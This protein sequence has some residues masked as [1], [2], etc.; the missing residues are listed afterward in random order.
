MPQSVDSY[1]VGV[2]FKNLLFSG[3]AYAITEE[4]SNK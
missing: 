4:P 2:L 1:R 3:I